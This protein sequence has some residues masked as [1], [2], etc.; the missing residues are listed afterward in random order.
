MRGTQLAL[1]VTAALGLGACG[2]GGS[3]NSASTPATT[4][5]ATTTATTTTAATTT[6]GAAV[7]A[8][9][10][11]PGT[12]LAQGQTAHVTMKPL[13]DG[14]DSKKRY[15]LDATVVKIEQAPKSDFKDV[16]L[17]AKQKAATPYYVRVRV[18]NTGKPFPS[19][20][21]DP[22]VRFDGIDDRGQKQGSVI[23]IGTFKPCDDKSAPDPFPKGK[24]YDSC[25]VYLIP[26]GGSISQVQWGGSDEYFSKPVV[27]K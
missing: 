22:D 11:P 6:T 18:A 12:V 23:L 2:S 26:G 4:T 27:W 8:G 21:D 17:D 10:T 1:L 16:N 19:K 13:A 7:P 24:S 25:L 14:F 5:S 9:S 15:T 3:S 20:Q